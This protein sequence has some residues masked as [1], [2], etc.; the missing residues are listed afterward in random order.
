MTIFWLVTSSAEEGSSAISTFGERIVDMA[1]TVRCFMPPDSSTACLS[2]TLAG[3]PSSAKRFSARS[4]ISFLLAPGSCTRMTS[5]TK[6]MMRW[7]GF[8][9]FMAAWGM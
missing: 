4:R 6:R 3:R 7:V 9:A 8:R 5:S 1:M 2:S